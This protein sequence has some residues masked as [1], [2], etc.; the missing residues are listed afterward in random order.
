MER[1]G[2]GSRTG[3]PSCGIWCARSSKRPRQKRARSSATRCAT[4]RRSQLVPRKA[5]LLRDRFFA[6]TAWLPRLVARVPATVHAKLLAGFLI[7]VLLLITLGAVGLQVLVRLNRRADELVKHQQRIAS[8]RQFQRDTLLPPSW[9]WNETTLETTLR[10]LNEF[11]YNLDQLQF[12]AMGDTEQLAKLREDYAE[13]IDV[14]SML[15]GLVRAGNAAE[16]RSLHLTKAGPLAARVERLTNDL[17]NKAEA[18]MAASLESSE[19]AYGRSRRAVI[20]FSVAS[21]VLAL[22]LGYAISWAIIGPV[23]QM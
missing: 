1:S 12:V 3:S 2:P 11:R 14:V 15:I 4:A 18:D 23:K 6:A 8:F 9:S 16:A 20:A 17:V 21:I 5:S 7:I 10:R 13:F 19:E 22:V